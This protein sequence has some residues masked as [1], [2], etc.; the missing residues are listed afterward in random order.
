[1]AA[2]SNRSASGFS[3]GSETMWYTSRKSADL[4]TVSPRSAANFLTASS[5]FFLSASCPSLARSAVNLVMSSPANCR[6]NSAVAF[7]WSW[8]R[9]AA[10]G[11]GWTNG[12]YPLATPNREP[13]PATPPPIGGS[14]SARNSSVLAIRSAANELLTRL[15]AG[16]RAGPWVA[17]APAM[18]AARLATFTGSATWVSSGRGGPPNG[19][20][21]QFAWTAAACCRLYA[22]YWARR[23]RSG[24]F[25]TAGAASRAAGVGKAGPSGATRNPATLASASDLTAPSVAALV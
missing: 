1:M 7:S 10:S 15:T 14:I 6:A 3:P 17:R 5:A 2:E 16:A 12:A 25:S 24:A 22:S 19:L 18:A 8:P 13:N 21:V 20:P 4:P 23:T 11:S 9:T